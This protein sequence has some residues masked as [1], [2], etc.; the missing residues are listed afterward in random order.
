MNI[1]DIDSVKRCVAGLDKGPVA[2]LVNEDDVDMP[3]TVS[4]HRNLGFSAIIQVGASDNG[5]SL[6]DMVLDARPG[7]DLW[8]AV[9]GLMP[10]LAG[11]WVYAGYNAE[12]LYFPFCETRTISDATQFVSEERRRSVFC[13][14]VDIYLDDR[15]L[16]ETGASDRDVYFDRSGYYALDRYSGAER[17]ERQLDV[18]GG[19]KWR[20][21]EHIPWERQ[22]IDRMCLFRAED[23]L[24][25]DAGYLL[26]DAEMNT[27]NCE[28]HRNLTCSVVSLR[29]AKSL[30]RNPGSA[31]AVGDFIWGQSER[32]DGTSTQLM[33]HGLMEPGQWF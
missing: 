24:K 14:T 4:H 23:G 32:F 26:N 6:A 19:L 18:Y 31:F 27:I 17:L 33:H 1:A 8:E 28:W 2:V 7:I 21:S 13:T 12:F 30:R 10:A 25:M 15:D 20:F 11:R 29:V 3:A 16:P 22:R 9:N 5:R